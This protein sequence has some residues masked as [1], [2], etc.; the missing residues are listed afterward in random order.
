MREQQNKIRPTFRPA[1]KTIPRRVSI[2][3]LIYIVG[4]AHQFCFDLDHSMTFS[5][6][7]YFEIGQRPIRKYWPMKFNQHMLQ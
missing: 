5:R 6:K 7:L 2:I 4:P 3:K 1:R